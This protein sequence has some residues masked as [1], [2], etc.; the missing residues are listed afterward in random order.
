MLWRSHE[1]WD[2]KLFKNLTIEGSGWTRCRSPLPFSRGAR[3]RN[4]KNSSEMRTGPLWDPWLIS[5]PGPP[6]YEISR[7]TRLGRNAF[8]PRRHPSPG[9]FSVDSVRQVLEFNARALL[10]N[11][12]KVVSLSL[13]DLRRARGCGANFFTLCKVTNKIPVF[14]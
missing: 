10:C 5:R 3:L 2:P 12:R 7:L 9:F 8:C 1:L 6:F 14:Y 13:S 11:V 4:S